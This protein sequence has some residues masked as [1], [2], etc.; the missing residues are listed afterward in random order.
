MEQGNSPA[1]EFCQTGAVQMQREREGT[2][3]A[4]SGISHAPAGIGGSGKE[5]YNRDCA[6]SGQRKENFGIENICL[7]QKRFRGEKKTFG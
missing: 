1:M 2:F 4:H 6:L 5:D 3:S 7:Q